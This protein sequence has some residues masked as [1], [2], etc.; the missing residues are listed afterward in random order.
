M[1]STRSRSGGL[2]MREDVEAE[3]QVL[4]ERARRDGAFARS[5]LVAAR[6]R[7]STWIACSLPT[8]QT[9]PDCSA[10]STLACADEI[11]VADLVEEERAAVGLLEEAALARRAR[12]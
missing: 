6:T 12:R 8:R 2:R 7:T 3:E 1:S 4:A 10:R 5:L 9:S 11:H